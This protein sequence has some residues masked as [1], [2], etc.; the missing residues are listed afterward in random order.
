MKDHW[1]VQKYPQVP[2]HEIV[3]IV[4][5]IEKNVTQFK[6]G[7]VGYPTNIVVNEHFVVH[8]PDHISFQ[9]AAPLLC[10]GITTYS[11]L[12]KL[13]LKKGGKVGI[14]GLGHM[15]IKLAV[16]KGNRSMPPPPLPVK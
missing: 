4:A 8:I 6:V 13:D 7:E 12:M 9:E 11:P 10:A 1:G 16:S 3:G 5:A 14:G 15:A 2:G